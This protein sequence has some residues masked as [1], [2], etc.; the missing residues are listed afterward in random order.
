MPDIRMDHQESDLLEA[1]WNPDSQERCI[2]CN[3]PSGGKAICPDERC[4]A[5]LRNG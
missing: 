5:E 2:V 1:V 4:A 3:R